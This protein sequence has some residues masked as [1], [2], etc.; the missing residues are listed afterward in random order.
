MKKIFTMETVKS[1]EKLDE[2]M[3]EVLQYLSTNRNESNKF[4]DKIWNEYVEYIDALNDSDVEA[5]G[6]TIITTLFIPEWIEE[7]KEIDYDKGYEVIGKL[8]LTLINS[9][10][11]EIMTEK[12]EEYLKEK[13]KKEFEENSDE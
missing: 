3:I 12:C 11:K 1:D 6:A 10:K 5:F 9:I 2:R 7:H 13:F 4:F 8:G